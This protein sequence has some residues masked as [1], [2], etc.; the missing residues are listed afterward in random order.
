MALSNRPSLSL[1]IL[2]FLHLFKETF[3]WPP[4]PLKSKVGTL[5][6]AITDCGPPV[7]TSYQSGFPDSEYLEHAWAPTPSTV[8]ST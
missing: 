6:L 5:L 1:K 8:L 7:T 2:P 4:L 3:P